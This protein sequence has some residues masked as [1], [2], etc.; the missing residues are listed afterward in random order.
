[1]ITKFLLYILQDRKDM[2]SIKLISLNQ[3]YLRLIS[4]A[5]MAA[6]WTKKYKPINVEI[7]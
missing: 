1:M 5:L 7:W 4:L 6:D 2:S 3:N